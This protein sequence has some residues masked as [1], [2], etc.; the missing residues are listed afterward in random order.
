MSEDG[1]LVVFVTDE[2]GKKVEDE[3]GNPVTEI[4]GFVGQIEQGG[5]VEDY[6]YYFTLPSGWKTVNDRGEFENK[7]QKSKL[8]IQ[9]AEETMNDNIAKKN[10]VYKVLTEKSNESENYTVLKNEYDNEKVGKI[11]TVSFSYDGV[12]KTSIS[13]ENS[14][15]T[16]QLD[17]ETE[18]EIALEDLEKEAMALIDSIEFKPYAYFENLTDA[19]TTTEKTAE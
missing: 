10:R 4:H 3:E 7:S 13:F 19:P 5:V 9:I 15:N 17:L 8:V 14:G 12:S 1:E 2:N 18:R 11:Y 6:A 16:Y